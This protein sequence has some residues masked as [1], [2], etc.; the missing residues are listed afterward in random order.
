MGDGEMKNDEMKDSEIKGSER[1]VRNTGEPVK[2]LLIWL[3]L[4]HI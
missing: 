3:S 1:K 2:R 4:I